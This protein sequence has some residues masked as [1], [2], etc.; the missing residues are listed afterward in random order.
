MAPG[1]VRGREPSPPAS[2]STPPGPGREAGVRG[3][4]PQSRTAR[5][6]DRIPRLLP[7]GDSSNPGAK[8]PQCW[9]EQASLPSRE[10]SWGRRGRTGAAAGV[11]G[12]HTAAKTWD[13]SQDAGDTHAH[14]TAGPRRSP[15]SSALPHSPRAG[16]LGRRC[17]GGRSPKAGLARASSRPRPTEPEGGGERGGAREV[18][19]SGTRR[20][21]CDTRG[22]GG[23]STSRAVAPTGR[24]RPVARPVPRRS[25]PRL[26]AP[27]PRPTRRG[28]LRSWV[29]QLAGSGA[30]RARP[31]RLPTPAL[32]ASRRGAD[33][34]QARPPHPTPRWAVPVPGG[35][36]GPGFRLAR[37]VT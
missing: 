19:A 25:R 3:P 9:A 24:R 37:T 13:R 10:K 11:A 8:V 18:P 2:K 20:R 14:V 33:P 23:L 29:P 30:M 17:P 15:G 28:R 4:F 21:A 6:P 16:G 5:I 26:W 31:L 32:L 1:Q 22:S 36:H 34:A 12:E 35:P 7:H 27:K